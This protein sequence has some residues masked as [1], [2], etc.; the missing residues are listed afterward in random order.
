MEPSPEESL[1]QTAYRQLRDFIRENYPRGRFVA[2]AGGKIVADASTFRDLD[3]V[4]H[5]MG[6]TSP[7]VLVAQ[8]GIE[9]P[10]NAT[11]PFLRLFEFGGDAD[12]F[13][14][15]SSAAQP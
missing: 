11:L 6:F 3:A 10:E 2:I 5:Q 4:L 13:W 9:Y 12:W 7:D 1:N 15:R 8:A 14:L